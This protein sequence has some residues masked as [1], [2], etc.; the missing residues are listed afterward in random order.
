MGRK[1]KAW[2]LPVGCS[3]RKEGLKKWEENRKVSV[4]HLLFYLISL[5]VSGWRYHLAHCP[6]INEPWS[7]DQESSPS[8]APYPSIL[9]LRVKAQGH[10]CSLSQLTL[11]E[12]EWLLPILFLPTYCPL[13]H[14]APLLLSQ[15]SK[16]ELL[17]WPGVQLNHTDSVR[18]L[19]PRPTV[20]PLPSPCG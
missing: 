2:K 15:H 9:F 1:D 13:G 8:M 7:W 20:P 4:L 3:N 12:G 5:S 10:L 19:P 11:L 16:D 14:S 18:Q 17:G 6:T